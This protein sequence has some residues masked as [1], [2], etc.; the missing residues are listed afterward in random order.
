MFFFIVSAK[1]PL[2]FLIPILHIFSIP[3][4]SVGIF[5]LKSCPNFALLSQ[6]PNKT[7]PIVNGLNVTYTRTLLSIRT[8]FSHTRGMFLRN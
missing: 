2:N 3:P 7:N 5:N 4:H 1:F 8:P 6:I